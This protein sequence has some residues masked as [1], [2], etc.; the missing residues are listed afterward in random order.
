M[1]DDD[2]EYLTKKLSSWLR[3]Q[4]LN[5]RNKSSFQIVFQGLKLDDIKKVDEFLNFIAL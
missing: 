5:E 2:V 4:K 3:N 1:N